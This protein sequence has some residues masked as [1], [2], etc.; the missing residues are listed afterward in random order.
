M[1][2]VVGCGR[3]D[4]HAEMKP[5]PA[6]LVIVTLSTTAEAPAATGATPPMA[7]TNDEPAPRRAGTPSP[8]RLSRMR[9]GDT[10]VYALAP[11]TAAAAG[12]TPIVPRTV[13]PATSAATAST[14]PR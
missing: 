14:L 11:V 9:V 2:D 10:A 8:A 1:T 13:M 6:G 5:G 3:S 12:C 4:G 7:R